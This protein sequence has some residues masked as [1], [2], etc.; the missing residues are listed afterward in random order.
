M[1]KKTLILIPVLVIIISALSGCGGIVSESYSA[2]GFFHGNATESAFMEF[3]KFRGT[4]VFELDTEKDDKIH[5][6]AKLDKGKIKVYL[7]TDDDKE[8][9]LTITAGDATEG[10]FG[11]GTEGTTLIVESTE[12]CEGGNIRFVIE[13][14]L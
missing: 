1:M 4:M 11:S 8:E 6:S 2:T 10:S 5:Y 7:K 9:L 3:K 14:T 12:T 13:E